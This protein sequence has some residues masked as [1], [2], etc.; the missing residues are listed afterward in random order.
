MYWENDSVIYGSISMVS[1]KL[2]HQQCNSFTF[3]Y[4]CWFNHSHTKS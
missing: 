3:C 4:W 1:G 2:L